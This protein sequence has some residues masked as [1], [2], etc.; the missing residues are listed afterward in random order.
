MTILL[1]VLIVALGVI[2]IIHLSGI[3]AIRDSYAGWG[4][5]ARF[6]FVTGLL[7]VVAAIS[8]AMPGSRAWGVALGAAICIAAVATLLRHKQW[9]HL[10][11]PLIL[12]IG[13]AVLEY[14]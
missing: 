7:E 13:F 4:Y 11:G 12:L 10:A 6:Y 5:P 3:K 14:I 9:S 1:W 2:G 8:M